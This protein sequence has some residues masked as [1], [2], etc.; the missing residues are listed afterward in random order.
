MQE[1]TTGQGTRWV[2][3]IIPAASDL[4]T[5]VA[6]SLWYIRAEPQ[7]T[8]AVAMRQSPE[9]GSDRSDMEEQYGRGLEVAR[10]FYLPRA[11][12]LALGF[13]AVAGVFL[14]NETH[15]F[16]W[17]ALALHGFVWPHAAYFVSRRSTDPYRAELRNLA[18][19]SGLAGVWIALMGAN[20]LPSAL[21]VAMLAMD[22]LSARGWRFMFQC[23]GL[24]AGAA[25]AAALLFGFDFQPETS[26]A[27]ILACLPLLAFYP[28][29]VGWT[30]FSFARRIADHNRLLATLS[31]TD[32]LSGLPT[33]TY[34][35]EV[36]RTEFD[37]YRRHGRDV[38]LLMIDIDHFKIVNDTWGHPC[39]D[40]VI[41]NIARILREAVRVKDTLGRYGGEEFGIVLPETTVEAA[42][43]V[44]E[45]IRTMVAA[46]VL[47][48]KAGVRA[49]VSIG[50]ACATPDMMHYG[51]WIEHADRALYRA[52]LAGRNRTEIEHPA[53]R[54]ALAA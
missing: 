42:L 51:E 46:T 9:S 31:R 30:T 43:V 38:C 11:L 35:E 33:R 1:R 29:V 26:S 19:D 27:Q 5:D 3:G 13:I 54:P 22:K 53:T 25:L 15:A 41:R 32:G 18:L 47:E 49:T 39:G 2:R 23:L 20:L 17:F 36:V 50:L 8:D 14:A 12:G 37:R 40:E 21:L 10:R 34:W 6:R 4:E 48:K 16:A 52:K 24:Q 45:R 7:L 44:A 28:L